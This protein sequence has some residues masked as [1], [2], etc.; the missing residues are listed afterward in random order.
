[1]M[2]AEG[3]FKTLDF[4]SEVTQMVAQEG[5]LIAMEASNVVKNSLLVNCRHV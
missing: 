5:L 3:I 2:G 1:M 4:I